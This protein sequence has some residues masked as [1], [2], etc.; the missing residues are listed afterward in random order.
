MESAIRISGATSRTVSTIVVTSVSESR[1]RFFAFHVEPVG[2]HFDLAFTFLAGNVQNP[3]T[4]PEIGADLKQQR[5]FADARRAADEHQRTAHAAPAKNAVKLPQSGG[6]PQLL[7]GIDL[8]ERPDGRTPPGAAL[9]PFA[10]D[11]GFWT[12][13]SMEFHAPQAGHCPCQRGN[14]LPQFLQ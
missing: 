13:S 7:L 14:S 1:S 12:N 2:T 8:A 11:A 6:K 10:A 5:R 9:F 3:L 4:F